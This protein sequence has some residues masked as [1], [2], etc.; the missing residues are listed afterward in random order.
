[1]TASAPRRLSKASTMACSTITSVG[2]SLYAL[3]QTI[4]T[5]IDLEHERRTLVESFASVLGPGADPGRAECAAVHRH[6][7]GMNTNQ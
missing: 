3:W 6:R 5:G 1:M 7:G 4:Q 2:S